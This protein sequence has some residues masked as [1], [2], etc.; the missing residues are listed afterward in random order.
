M[1][2]PWRA[3]CLLVAMTLSA[4]GCR[5]GAASSA[6]A[7]V[8]K[9]QPAPAQA[10]APAKV[11]TLASVRLQ[12]QSWPTT[13]RVQ[14]SLLGEEDAVIGTK[15]AGRVREVKVDVGKAVQVGDVL[16]SLEQENFQWKV[17]QAQAQ[18]EQALAK[19]GLKPGQDEKGLNPEAIPEVVQEK[20]LWDEAAANL[21]RGEALV[22]QNAIS[23]EEV[24]QRQADKDVAE[25][26]YHAALNK[27][28]EELATLEMRRAE[29]GLAQQDL[30]DSVIR[31]PYA[32]T[33]QQRH[34]APG[35]YLSVGQPVVTLVKVDPLRFRAGVPERDAMQVKVGQQVH[36]FIVGEEEPR[37]AKVS[38]INP[39]LDLSSRSLVIEADLANSGSSL[40][41]GLFAEAEIVVD[42]DAKALAVRQEAILEFAGVEKVWRVHNGEASQQ[43]VTT[44]RRQAAMVEILGGL[45]EGDIVLSDASQGRAGPV[46]TTGT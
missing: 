7:A 43:E 35:V 1:S 42:P 28:S 19:L 41:V 2:G 27:V 14:G 11:S 16:A 24:Q 44:G 23:A 26:R 13:V 8:G 32:G 40:P 33:V 30:T 36:V 29:L 39:S 17:L 15:V 25:A 31:A 4:A 12:M 9:A 5:D 3:G 21:K 38:R 22:Q 46:T 45:S 20:A 18:L 6:G 34:V 37:T 10:T